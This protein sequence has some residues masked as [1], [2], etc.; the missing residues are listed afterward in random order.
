MTSTVTARTVVAVADIFR[1]LFP[2]ASVTGAPK[3]SS[4]KVINFLESSQRE[5]YTGAIGYLAPNRRAQFNV[6][7]RTAVVNKT[8]GE[9]VY[10]VGSGIVSDSDPEEEHEECLVKSE[11]LSSASGDRN[12]SL[13]ETMLF[14]PE[15]GLFLLDYHINR[16]AGSAA[17]FGFSF[18]EAHIRETLDSLLSER[19]NDHCRIRLVLHRDG[20]VSLQHGPLLGNVHGGPQLVRLAREPVSEGNRFLYHKTT[21]RVVYDNAMQSVTDCDDVLLWNSQGFVT[22]TTIANVVVEIGGRRVTPPVSCGL[23]GG[24]YR[25]WLLDRGEIEEWPIHLDDIHNIDRFTL[26]NSV[27]GQWAAQLLKGQD[28]F[29]V[30]L[31]HGQ[32]R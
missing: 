29:P 10:G 3:V 19:E 31:G 9:S 1:A 27:R 15:E 6:A 25:Q 32:N 24:T 18:D 28:K 23:L 7:I 11:V 22:E 30:F 12:F 5:V 20:R 26:I 14:V 17:Y 13:L 21:R 2:S 8:S 16:L 4:M